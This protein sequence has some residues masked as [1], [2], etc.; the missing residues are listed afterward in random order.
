MSTYTPNPIKTDDVELPEGIQPLMEKL[1]EHIHDIWAQGRIDEG[2]TFGEK[3]DDDKKHHPD[4]RPYA[5]LTDGEKAYDRSTVAASLKAIRTLPPLTTTPPSRS[6]H[7]PPASRSLGD[8]FWLVGTI[9][10]AVTP[11]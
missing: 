10:S 9:A 3:R 1:A 8:T 2:W 4:L 7:V 6:H 11:S 5:E